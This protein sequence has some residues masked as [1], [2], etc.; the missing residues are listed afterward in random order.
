MKTIF[1]YCI[2]NAD[3]M[4]SYQQEKFSWKEKYHLPILCQV[5]E[6]QNVFKAIP[7]FIGREDIL[8]SINKKNYYQAYAEILLWGQIGARPGSNISKKTD[9]ALRALEYPSDKVENIF[10]IVEGGSSDKINALFISLERDGDNKIKEVDVSYFTKILSFASEAFNNNMK[11]LIYDKWTRLIHVH[12]LLDLGK[13]EKL[14]TFYTDNSLR[15]LYFRSEKSKKPSTK[16]IYSKANFGLKVYLDYCEELDNLASRIS[17]KINANIS[18][19]QLEGYLFGRELKSKQNKN[20]NNPRFWI[21]NNYSTTYL[22][23]I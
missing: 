20:D 1:D 16:L 8:K 12:L 6:F 21:Q 2:Q 19:F 23:Q 11:L 9:I 15:S 7:D 5:L 3:K 17:N 18:S 13:Q 14:R 4:Q 22:S 10:K